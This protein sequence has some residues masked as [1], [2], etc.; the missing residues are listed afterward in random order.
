MLVNR[1]EPFLPILPLPG[2]LVGTPGPAVCANQLAASATVQDPTPLRSCR[3][4]S[5]EVY[6]I[7]SLWVAAV[8]PVAQGCQKGWARGALCAIG[9]GTAVDRRSLKSRISLS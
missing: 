3:A 8:S 5:P 2:L 4:W 9:G 1:I 6:V 7:S